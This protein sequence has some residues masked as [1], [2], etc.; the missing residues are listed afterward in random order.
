VLAA[1]SPLLGLL[2]TVS[3]I[4]QTFRIITA[5]GNGDPKLLSAGISEALLTT[6]A[7]LLVA[8]P[9]LLCHHF[10]TRRVN[11]VMLDMEAAGTSLIAAGSSGRQQ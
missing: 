8:I 6:E 5:H 11:T 7:G 1:I 9:L 2:G 4:I 3:G 10:L